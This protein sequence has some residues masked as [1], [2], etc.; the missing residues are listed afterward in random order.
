MPLVNNEQSKGKFIVLY[1]INNL[2]KTVQAELLVDKLNEE[3]YKAE[4]LKY[5]IYDL[6]PSGM[7]INDY[8]RHSNYYK[9]SPREIQTFYTFNRTQF[10]HEL[11]KKLVGGITVIAE[12]YTGTGLA[13]GIG[14][15]VDENFLKYL[16]SHLLT[17]D[18]A[19]LL[20]GERF[21]AGIETN[22]KHERDSE[23]TDQVREVHLR[24]ALEKNWQVINANQTIEQVHE[25]IWQQTQKIIRSNND[26]IFNYIQKKV[27]NTQAEKIS[28][29]TIINET[30]NENI[31]YLGNN[32]EAKDS[33]ISQNLKLKIQKIPPDAKIPTRAH[34]H[35]AGLDIYANDYY[36]L[37]EN[38]RIAIA[39]GIKLAIPPGYVGLVWDKSGIA[40]SGLHAIGG[41]I[42]SDYRGELKILVYNISGDIYNIKKGQK[43]AQLL[44]QEIKTPDVIES[45]DLNETTRNEGG[46]GSSGIY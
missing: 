22:H 29:M 21:S 5:P 34:E 25:K 35:D 18:L 2:G 38:E 24:L 43:I 26:Q 6:V 13:W 27:K 33:D 31:Q 44:I 8:L 46:F 10:Q 12:D 30:F 15:G 37:Y 39:T 1:G 20:D 40:A 36:T 16:N 14:A 7:I 23:L 3:G 41:V 17:E 42:D 28:E 4:Y 19:I 32:N 45:G 9:L 11:E